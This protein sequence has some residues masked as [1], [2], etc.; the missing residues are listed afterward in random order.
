MENV[1]KM[2]AIELLMTTHALHTRFSN[3]PNFM[4]PKELS[5]VF[6]D[7][8]SM[9]PRM[10]DDRY[11]KTDYEAILGYIQRDLPLKK[12]LVNPMSDSSSK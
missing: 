4:I 8:A 2:L 10:D 3:K 5:R 6:V 7:C 1:Q 11:L 12:N 9:S